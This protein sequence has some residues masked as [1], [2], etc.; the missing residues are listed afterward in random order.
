MTSLTKNLI[1]TAGIFFSTLGVNA[2]GKISDYIKYNKEMVAQFK[3]FMKTQKFDNGN[4]WY[5]K[6]DNTGN[7]ECAVFNEEDDNTTIYS[8]EDGYRKFKIIDEKSDGI[9]I[10]DSYCFYRDSPIKLIQNTNALF[11][12]I[13]PQN[14]LMAKIMKE[15][16]FKEYGNFELPAEF[17]WKNE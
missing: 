1:L 11:K 5:L 12:L 15:N 8:Y 13:H 2:Q 10:G 9:D 16:N 7:G 3:E 4:Y 6:Y 14:Y 17:R